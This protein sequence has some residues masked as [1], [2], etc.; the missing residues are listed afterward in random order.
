MCSLVMEARFAHA[1][2]LVYTFFCLVTIRVFSFYPT[3]NV[4]IACFKQLS[5][6]KREKD[7]ISFWQIECIKR[8]FMTCAFVVDT[9]GSLFLL[10]I[11]SP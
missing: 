6:W 11:K 3:L 1:C 7:K 2:F 10:K 5:S 8:S 9:L 4:V